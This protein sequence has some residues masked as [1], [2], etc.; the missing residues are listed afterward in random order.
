MDGEEVKWGNACG[1]ITKWVPAVKERGMSLFLI[2]L[3]L[4]LPLRTPV[5]GCGVLLCSL[6][7]VWAEGVPVADGKAILLS[8]LCH[9]P[10]I[11]SSFLISPAAC[12]HTS[13][14]THPFVE[15]LI[16]SFALSRHTDC[17]VLL[18]EILLLIF[19]VTANRARGGTGKGHIIVM[20]QSSKIGK[21]VMETCSKKTD[22]WKFTDQLHL[23][24][25]RCVCL[26]VDYATE[27]KL[28]FK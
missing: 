3:S 9:T 18:L 23:K 15:L 5:L 7:P 11:P 13:T 27:G 26:H 4:S 19:Q 25:W 10:E 22:A 14:H 28:F 12:A 1:F 16:W 17:I 20:D 6:R 21:A 8:Q 2:P 24:L